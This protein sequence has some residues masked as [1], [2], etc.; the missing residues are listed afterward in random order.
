LDDEHVALAAVVTELDLETVVREPRGARRC[1]LGPEDGAD[2][3][4]E[5]MMRGTREDG[6]VTHVARE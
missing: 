2:L 1:D 6:D 4:G 3:L 5:L